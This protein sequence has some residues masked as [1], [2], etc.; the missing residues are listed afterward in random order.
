MTSP[1]SWKNDFRAHMANKG[2]IQQLAE[3]EA[4]QD[5]RLKAAENRKNSEAEA[6]HVRKKVWGQESEPEGEDM[7][8]TVLGDITHP[9]PVI[10]TGGSN[11]Q[12][13]TILT[14]AALAAAVPTMGLAGLAGFAASQYLS[15][16]VAEV[17]EQQP[18]QFEDQSVDIGL[19]K[20]EDY[21]LAE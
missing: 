17:V 8:N 7:G 16:P 6:A 1:A 18:Q 21:R 2:K 4:V 9:A 20:L 13:G 12:L 11:S 3:L 14:A 19:G 10:V 15:S 5:L